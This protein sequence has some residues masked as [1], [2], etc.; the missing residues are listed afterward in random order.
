[1]TTYVNASLCYLC[2]VP[3]TVLDY[4]LI[5]NYNNLWVC[6]NCEKMFPINY[7][8]LKNGQCSICMNYKLLIKQQNCFHYLCVDCYKKEYFGVSKEERPIHW[9][10]MN[11]E[12]PDWPFEIDD[13]EYDENNEELIKYQEY[14]DF[15]YDYFDKKNKNYNELVLIRN[16]LMLKRPEW[17]NTTIF[18]NYENSIFKYHTE[19]EK[20][21][22]NWEFFNKNKIIGKQCCPFCKK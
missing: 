8:N 4:R 5:N 7:D 22:K 14:I 2:D 6:M 17:M 10:E 18:M 11:I 21:I 13:D 12:C 15:D 9:H 16:N 20:T 19:Y 3:Y 1:M